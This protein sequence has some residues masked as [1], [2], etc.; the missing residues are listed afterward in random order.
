MEVHQTF[1][2]RNKNMNIHVALKSFYIFEDDNFYH[3]E[4]PSYKRNQM[5]FQVFMH[6]M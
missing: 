5:Y 6:I 4:I 3:M 2:K 1:L